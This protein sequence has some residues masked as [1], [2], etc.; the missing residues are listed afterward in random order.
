ML[1]NGGAGSHCIIFDEIGKHIMA[2]NARLEANPRRQRVM[3]CQRSFAKN[4]HARIVPVEGVSV[5][6][7]CTVMAFQYQLPHLA[8]IVAQCCTKCRLKAQLLCQ[9]DMITSC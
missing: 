9:R 4:R 2:G 6:T 5:F 3:Y 1:V 7:K 8:E